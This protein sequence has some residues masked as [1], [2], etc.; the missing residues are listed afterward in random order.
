[1]R[2]SFR[3]EGEVF[4][5]TVADNGTGMG[6]RQPERSGGLGWRLLRALAA[7]L[8]GRLET[9]GG[10]VGGTVCRLRFPVPALSAPP[11]PDLVKARL[12]AQPPA[13]PAE[14]PRLRRGMGD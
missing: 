14:L 11:R 13:A 8:G 12:E 1:V 10:E 5:L 4:E 6:G 9:A 2:V 7:Q 3:R